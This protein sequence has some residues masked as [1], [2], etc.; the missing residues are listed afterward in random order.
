MIAFGRTCQTSSWE[1]SAP[2]TSN[3][4]RRSRVL[5][6][7]KVRK[8][9]KN[10]YEPQKHA[11]LTCKNLDQMKDGGGDDGKSD[12][13]MDSE[14][15]KLQDSLGSGFCK[16]VASGW[17]FAGARLSWRIRMLRS[18]PDTIC[19]NLWKYAQWSDVAGLETAKELLKEAVILPIK[20]PHLFVGKRWLPRAC[21]LQKDFHPGL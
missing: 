15:K 18:V 14:T 21:N 17:W 12:D 8:R 3:G 4:R 16:W 20:L 7:A 6:L 5:S 1:N 10:R 11:P 13:E 2:S 19:E 9:R